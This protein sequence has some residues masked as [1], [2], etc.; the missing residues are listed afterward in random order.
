MKFI[1]SIILYI[2]ITLGTA[3]AAT[4]FDECPQFF[5]NGKPPVVAKKNETDRE[6]CYAA[7]AILHSGES[8]TPVFVAE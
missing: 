6:L 7:F 1:N 4:G 8:K 2:Y 5:V 3:L